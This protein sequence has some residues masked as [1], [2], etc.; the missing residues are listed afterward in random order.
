M[1]AQQSESVSYSII[2][3]ITGYMKYCDLIPLR[4]PFFS[5]EWITTTVH[6][7]ITGALCASGGWVAKK[8]TEIGY[9]ALTEYFRS[10]KAKKQL[11]RN[12]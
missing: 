7:V 6:A 4:I 10:R 9:N 1:S 8:V 3:L 12:Q 5:T 2:A 11:K